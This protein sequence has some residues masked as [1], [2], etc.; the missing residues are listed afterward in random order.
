MKADAMPDK[1]TISEEEIF[2]VAAAMSSKERAAYVNSAC[3]GH[4]T[5]KQRV[6]RL[7]ASHE[8]DG[9]MEEDVSPSIQA[10]IARLVPEDV[11]DNIG[12]YRLLQ[13]IGH[14]GFGVVWMVE[15]SH[16]V[17]RRVA[18][19]IV[20]LG[21]DTKEVVARFEQER[22]ALALMDHPNIARVFDAGVTPSGRPYFVMELV[23]GVKL[24]EFCD[25]HALSMTE[26]ME[27]FVR[28]CHAVH[29]A[30]QKGIIHRD[31]KPSNILVGMVDGTAVPK[32]IDFGVAKATQTRITEH[33]LYTEI[34][35]IIGTPLYMSP[36][37]AETTTLD[38]DTRSDVYSLGILLYELLTGHT[39]FTRDQMEQNGV[40]GIRKIIREQE[41]QRPSTALG[42]IGREELAA[43]AHHRHTEAPHLVGILKRDLD[44]IVMRAIE[45]DRNRRYDSATALAEDIERHLRSEP[46]VA[47][48]PTIGYRT[49][50]L[51]MRNKGAFVTAA[52]VTM[53]LV[54]GTGVSVWQAVRAS[55][56]A[57]RA[58]Q[59][60][61]DLRETAPAFAAMARELAAMESWNAAIDK[62]DYA[63]RL[64]PANA[65]FRLYRADLFQ[66]Q[67]RLVE[68][69]ADYR[70]ALNAAPDNLRAGRNLA[71]CEK[72]LAQ[73]VQP[74]GNLSRETLAELLNAV[75]A[76]KRPA[77][78]TMPLA[79]RIGRENEFALAH[80]QE[81]LRGLPNPTEKSIDARI[82]ARP[83]GFL[84]LDLRGTGIADL[85]PLKGMPL[86]ELN[87][88]GCEFVRDIEALRDA[89]LRVL[90]LE[91][92]AVTDLSPLATAR[93][94]YSLNLNHTPASDLGPL[95]TLPLRLLSLVHGEV[96]DLTPLRGLQL[97]HLELGN[98]RGV[99]S[100]APLEGMPLKVLDCSYTNITDFSPLAKL[101]LRQL[102]LQGAT[103]GDLAFL[104]DIPLETLV[105]TKARS[106]T[107]FAAL[108]GIKTLKALALPE[109]LASLPELELDAI[110]ALRNHPALQRL[111]SQLPEGEVPDA[112]Q[113]TSAFWAAWDA[114]TTW[115]RAMRRLEIKAGISK[116]SDG[117]W[118][119]IAHSQPL[120]DLTVFTGSNISL[121]DVS[122]CG[123][124]SD[125]S[126]L[127]ALP[128][129]T[130]RI[131]NTKVTD[132]SPLKGTKVEDLWIS[133]T[134]VADLTPLASL[135][136]RTLY[137]DKSKVPVDFAPLAN[138]QTLEELILPEYPSS[139]E[140]L[141][142]LPRLRH[143]SF[144]FDSKTYK[145]SRTAAAFWAEWDT[146]TWLPKL[147][148][149]DF[150]IAQLSSGVTV[151]VIRDPAFRDL[152]VLADAK[153]TG[154]DLRGS[155]VTDLAPL[156][157]MP[158]LSNLI[159]P[160]HAANVGA[161][162]KSPALQRIST[163]GNQ[164]KYEPA[165]TAEEF[166]REQD[167][168]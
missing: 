61:S 101:P 88:S 93:A 162:R 89:P 7:L 158:M 76:E 83:D 116:R 82:E 71:L 74:D 112:A 50:R 153:I 85:S 142:A 167:G 115:Q 127:A 113:A 9:F 134:D 68:A 108:S 43:V 129:K 81:R 17:R 106:V 72:L 110:Q 118:S 144:T 157:G 39:P 12:P 97:E 94:L 117:T 59:A 75:S 122:S 26:R 65:D 161:L 155:G 99:G 23:R 96:R 90:N 125:L 45:K 130:L 146:F 102:W 42:T 20:K 84:S 123:E 63:I 119:V 105:L 165:Q 4:P 32:I 49:R 31:L 160:E 56:N 48:P 62:L 168:L 103:V 34:G 120:K 55:E 73:P 67:G 107:N 100:L 140:K 138:L 57:R 132:L 47:R 64:Q 143:I 111:S 150:T 163:T 166:W 28:I 19:K 159:I 95:A 121:L 37:Q 30:H 46:V 6:E 139:V 24:T 22:Q 152:A 25:A 13:E 147:K 66:A 135:P 33:S 54:L 104:R 79:R 8:S 2:L 109:G 3:D 137:M 149:F 29:H 131:A 92:T 156:A 126:P 18:L 98:A 58:N 38:I 114:D 10:R 36:E 16:P 41:P 15:Q 128:L 27:L 124:I 11:G 21:M 44:W 87:L 91:H 60:L 52:I 77:A 136:I 40:E 78:E 154:L 51:V 53:A 35:Q 14:G 69:A 148:G 70:A 145:P 80:W 86:G 1:N 133:N 151:L 141:R 164:R 5:L